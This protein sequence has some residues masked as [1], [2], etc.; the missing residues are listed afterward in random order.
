[1]KNEAPLLIDSVKFEI[2]EIVFRKINPEV[3]GMV[4]GITFRPT[5]VTYCCTFSDEAEEITCYDIELSRD[6]KL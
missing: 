5:G 6:K 3:A 4:T 2:G 1:M